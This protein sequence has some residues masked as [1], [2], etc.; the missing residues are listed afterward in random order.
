M[1]S[2]IGARKNSKKVNKSTGLCVELRF[3]R[4]SHNGMLHRMKSGDACIMRSKKSGDSLMG[5]SHH[6]LHA[7]KPLSIEA[8][9]GDVE[10]LFPESKK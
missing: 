1:V 7:R 8:G 5:V 10:V 2:I 9:R 3:E 4:D 6:G